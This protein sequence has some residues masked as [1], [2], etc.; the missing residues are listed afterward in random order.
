MFWDVKEAVL[1]IIGVFIT[2]KDDKNRLYNLQIRF[3]FCNM[4]LPSVR[5]L[6]YSAYSI[7]SGRMLLPFL[8]VIFI[9]RLCPI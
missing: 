3:L 4:F 8:S 1:N 6:H 7:S 9:F 2:T 5:Y